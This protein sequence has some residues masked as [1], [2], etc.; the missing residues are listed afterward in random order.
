[1]ANS[2]PEEAEFG[3]TLRDFIEARYSASKAALRFTSAVFMAERFLALDAVGIDDKAY[4]H[5]HDMLRWIAINLPDGMPQRVI[6]LSNSVIFSWIDVL[7][8][9]KD[10]R[11]LTGVSDK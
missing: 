4:R 5:Q 2:I 7:G 3:P 9:T 10:R 11:E 6:N 8:L 1:V